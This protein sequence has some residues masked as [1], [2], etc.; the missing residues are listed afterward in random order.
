MALVVS[1]MQVVVMVVGGGDECFLTGRYITF[2][3]RLPVLVFMMVC[4]NS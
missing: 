2:V 4:C 3:L 1:M